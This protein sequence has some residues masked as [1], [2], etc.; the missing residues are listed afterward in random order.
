M[1]TTHVDFMTAR[2]K[3]RA[4]HTQ[5]Q[6]LDLGNTN[7]IKARAWSI[8]QNNYSQTHHNIFLQETKDCKYWIIG[9]EVAPTTGTQHLQV[10]LYYKNARSLEDMKKTF[11]QAHIEKA[12]GTP[13]QNKV[14]CSKEH[15]FETNF[16]IEEPVKTIKEEQLYDWQKK[17]EDFCNNEPDDRTIYWIHEP[18]GKTGKSSFCKYMKVKYEN[19]VCITTSAKS[20]D[21]LTSV[22]TYY[23]TYI[24]DFTRS[25][26]GFEPFNAIEQ[27]KN[28][29]ITDGKL[30]KKSRC[31]VFNSPN[32]ICFSNFIPNYHKLSL[33]R[34]KIY[35]IINNDL[36]EDKIEEETIF[37]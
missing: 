3:D 31:L 29:L 13:E 35:K 6:L 20:N 4:R 23:K 26:E 28:G 8:T 5:T 24:F 7:Q 19:K 2:P 9:K 37:N 21:I 25:Q 12:K 22:E 17:V 1:K 27:I 32:I 36:V 15:D 11:P 18:I 34:W 30:K 14:Y 16:I 33:D 10:Y